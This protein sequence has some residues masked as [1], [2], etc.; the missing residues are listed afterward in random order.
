MD[1]NNNNNTT[2]TRTTISPISSQASMQGLQ[3]NISNTSPTTIQSKPIQSQ[4]I[5]HN[6]PFTPTTSLQSFTTLSSSVTNTPSKKRVYNSDN[7]SNNDNTFDHNELSHLSL[8][9]TSP[10][11]NIRPVK[12]SMENTTHNNTDILIDDNDDDN[13]VNNN[14]YTS[15][16]NSTVDQDI[17]DSSFFDLLSKFTKLDIPS[18]KVPKH[19][20]CPI[21]ANTFD[22]NIFASHVYDCIKKLDEQ[23]KHEL[24][25]LD[26]KLARQIAEQ[27]ETLAL[28]G[29]L[30]DN[31]LNDNNSKLHNIDES[32][33]T[34][35]TTS[36]D[37]NVLL[38]DDEQDNISLTID[39]SNNGNNSNTN[40]TSNNDN[41]I[42]M[43]T[44]NS[45]VLHDD[46]HPNTTADEYKHM[47]RKKRRMKRLQLN[48]NG[49]NN[50]NN[51]L[52][53]LHSQQPSSLHHTNNIKQV[54]PAGKSC[55]RTDATHFIILSHPDVSCP[56]CD[57]SL[58]PYE[59]EAHVTMCLT[60]DN[61]HNK[62]NNHSNNNTSSIKPMNVH[63]NNL[64]SHATTSTSSPVLS[65]TSINDYVFPN[66]NNNNF[67]NYT[68]NNTN[69]IAHIQTN[70]NE[71][72]IGSSSIICRYRSSSRSQLNGSPS[73][74]LPLD[75]QS[76]SDDDNSSSNNAVNNNKKNKLN[77]YQAKSI[78][79]LVLSQHDKPAVS[80]DYSL[81]ELLNTFKTLGFTQKNLTSLYNQHNNTDNDN[82]TTVNTNSCLNDTTSMNTNTDTTVVN[83]PSITNA[84]VNNT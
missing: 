64:S 57:Q 45:I 4:L 52:Q 66:N 58:P 82:N 10:N 26:E 23:E 72:T 38:A 22:L 39:S 11:N 21:C 47:K 12:K 44:L 77:I 70:Y 5:Q 28:Q 51:S 25:L 14:I 19:D 30:A 31:E 73:P 71:P 68:L 35:S 15:K 81:H 60:A 9:T 63:T 61:N 69:H 13:N 48:N 29:S 54:C 1:S 36:D 65:T 49:N 62:A 80:Q 76:N 27:E 3:F 59:I 79:E 55:T 37:N 67:K 78:A 83:N 42:N 41:N 34:T 74:K 75:N 17:F 84:T 16:N 24:Y 20:I 46:L 18:D 2:T 50:N 32:D 33:T 43:V 56:L 7:N 53:S 8:D 6:S 40:M